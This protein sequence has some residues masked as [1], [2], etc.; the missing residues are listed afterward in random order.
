MPLGVKCGDLVQFAEDI[1][2]IYSGKTHEEVSER[3]LTDLCSLSLWIKSSHMEVN[4]KINTMWFNV[5]STKCFK[6]PQILLNRSPLS[7]VSTHKYLGIQIDDHLKWHSHVSYLCKKM[8]YYLYLISHHHK[9]LP[10]PIL[11]NWWSPLFC[12]I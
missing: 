2:V 5:C 10:V 6:P 11:K 7:Q 4:V 8:A 1:C 12:H 3:L 9:V